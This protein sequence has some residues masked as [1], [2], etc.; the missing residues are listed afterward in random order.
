MFVC[1]TCLA[2]AN[3]RPKGKKNWRRLSRR[4]WVD[5]LSQSLGPCELCHRVK[6][7]VDA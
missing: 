6:V 7:C 3:Q 4:D 1:K 2:K 5:F